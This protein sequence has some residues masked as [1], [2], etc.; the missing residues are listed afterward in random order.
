M[1]KL[2]FSSY[3][4]SVFTVSQK[5]YKRYSSDPIE[6]CGRLLYLYIILFKNRLDNNI[7]YLQDVNTSERILLVTQKISKQL[8]S[9]L[10]F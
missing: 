2:L 10:I 3:F 6:K 9:S 5:T 4:D 1:G 8:S 7:Q